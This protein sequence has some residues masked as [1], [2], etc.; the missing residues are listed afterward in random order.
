MV[1]D[2]LKA[3]VFTRPVDL[4]DKV[5]LRRLAEN[6]AQQMVVGAF[7]AAIRTL[8][9]AEVS[10]ELIDQDLRLSDTPAFPWSRETVSAMRAI[11]NLTPAD[12]ALERRFAQFL[13]QA[14]DVDAFAKL[15]MTAA[16]PWS[17]SQ[18]LA[19]CATTTRTF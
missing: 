13:D 16:S 4:A 5:I 7:Q 19:P 8:T 14:S 18:L 17:T 11:F 1:R 2:Y 3:R 12:N 10:P 6:D 15:T 9:I